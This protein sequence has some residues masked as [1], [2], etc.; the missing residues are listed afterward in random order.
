MGLGDPQD[1]VHSLVS[2][3]AD[4]IITD[5]DDFSRVPSVGWE[6][7]QQL[8]VYVVQKVLPALKRAFSTPQ[9][10]VDWLNSQYFSA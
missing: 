2:V 10:C 8:C 5:G 9:K 7:K 3:V 6:L 4:L 1:T